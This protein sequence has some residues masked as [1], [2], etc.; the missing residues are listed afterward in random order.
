[1]DLIGPIT[2]VS[3]DGSVYIIIA[4]VYFTRH[5]W[6]RTTKKADEPTVVAFLKSEIEKSHG[7]PKSI[8][9][10]IS[11]KANFKNI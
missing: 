9:P 4:V 2:P 5:L 3:I 8:Y 6:T 1:M 7:F 10:R 11:V